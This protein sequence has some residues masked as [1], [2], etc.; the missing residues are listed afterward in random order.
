MESYEWTKKKPQ[1]NPPFPRGGHSCALLS[2]RDCMII[3]GGWS[4]SS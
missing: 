2:D 3:Y 1:G 4:N